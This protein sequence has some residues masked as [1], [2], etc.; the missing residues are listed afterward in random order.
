MIKEGLNNNIRLVFQLNP[1]VYNVNGMGELKNSS[2]GNV[3][4][5]VSGSG[6]GSCDENVMS[7]LE[8]P[9]EYREDTIYKDL[10]IAANSHIGF[11]DRLKPGS[12]MFLG[13]VPGNYDD[14]DKTDEIDVS[15]YGNLTLF[16]KIMAAPYGAEIGLSDGNIYLDPNN[17]YID[18]RGQTV[19]YYHDQWWDVRSYDENLAGYHYGFTHIGYE[20]NW[21]VAKNPEMYLNGKI[22]GAV[23]TLN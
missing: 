10:D 20:H 18:D 1:S 17:T 6:Q 9:A 22:I 8:V 2:N 11:T 3:I 5:T 15:F 16:L 12:Y 19:H 4:C 7:Y 14:I 13:Y 23:L 21:F